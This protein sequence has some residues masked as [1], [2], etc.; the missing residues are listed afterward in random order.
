MAFP[1]RLR[2]SGAEPDILWTAGFLHR[3]WLRLSS[4]V[5]DIRWFRRSWLLPRS[6]RVQQRR[7]FCGRECSIR[8]R[9]RLLFRRV[10]PCARRSVLLMS[11]QSLHILSSSA[12]IP[13]GSRSPAEYRG[14]GW[15]GSS[16]TCGSVLRSGMLFRRFRPER[17]EALIPSSRT[18][19][20]GCRVCCVPS[21]CMFRGGTQNTVRRSR[22]GGVCCLL[23]SH[24][25][26]RNT[27]S[28]MP[29]VLSAH[30]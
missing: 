18:R 1:Q 8:S 21:R 10:L 17:T 20:Y 25:A 27:F 26:R 4:A 14:T 13:H 11:P 15:S 2:S 29:G 12:H 9:S 19:S 24:A 30:L 23:P 7:F 5:P 28:Q 3:Q 6:H 16:P 22:L